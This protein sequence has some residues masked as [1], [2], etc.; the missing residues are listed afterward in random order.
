MQSR[1]RTDFPFAV[2]CIDPL[3]IPLSDGVRLAATVWRP[4]TGAPCP[5][6]VEMIPYRRRDG[7]AFRDLDIH[8]YWAGFGMACVRVDIRGTGDSDGLLL[9]EYLPQEQE[10]AC[11]VIAWLAAQ[12]WSNGHVGMTGIS[13][14]GFN[15][16]Q[17]AARR[18]PA[19]KAIITLC[20]SDDRYSDDIHYMGG[21]LI[22][23]QEMWSNFML[24]KR[25]MP[26]DP[27]IVGAR[28]RDLWERRLDVNRSLSEIWLSHQRRDDYWKQGSVCEDYGAI[29]AAV[30]AVCGWDDSY[31]NFVPR[32]LANLRCPKLGIQGPWTHNFPCRDEPGPNIGYLQEGLRWWKHWLAGEE[33]G[34]MDE[35]QYR[36]WITAEER[37]K[38]FYFPDHRGHWVAEPSWPSANV[39]METY[40]L[41][42]GGTLGAAPRPG[43]RRSIRPPATAGTD[44]GRWGGYGGEVPDMPIDQR[45]EDGQS[46]CFDTAPLSEDVCL[47]GAPVVDL[48][49]EVDQPRANLIARLCDV[50]PDG[51]SALMTYG[52]LNLTHR[53]GHEFPADCPVGKPFRVRLQLN[54]FGR[55]VEKGH[56]IRIAL[57]TQHW[58]IVWPQPKLVAFVC[59]PGTGRLSLPIRAPSP[60]DDKVRFEPPEIAMPLPTETL[61]P[62]RH[63]RTVTDDGTTGLRSIE[64]FSDHGRTF[65]LDRHIETASKVTDSFHI[66]PDDPLSARLVQEYSWAVRSG[67]ADT[68]AVSRTELTADADFFYLTWRIEAYERERIV[69]TAAATKKIKR[70]FT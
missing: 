45:R 42:D 49:I 63:S 12:S 8:P 54:D 69:H 39:R 60:L 13:W 3:W 38:P 59:V 64:L 23:E 32:L 36:V 30:M 61:A 51:T 9:D 44:C 11:E 56:R 2:E 50:Y 28:W 53:D 37:P 70:D 10:D 7:T 6:V 18:P 26:P 15:S 41:N 46:L 19:L 66:L 58:P 47:L 22:T 17:V 55:M 34:I 40:H 24:V 31:S 25:A 33:T 67:E 35:P 29:G 4:K 65:I 62:A 21:A 5:V 43:E 57:S 16:L 1:I 20:A 27:Q 68:R 48:D 52:V 14:G